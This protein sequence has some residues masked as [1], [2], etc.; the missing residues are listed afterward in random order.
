LFRYG[1]FIK[2]KIVKKLEIHDQIKEDGLDRGCSICGREMKNAY[3]ILV[4]K[5]GRRSFRR[6]RH[7]W[8]DN[9]NMLS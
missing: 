5:Q 7:R 8:E 4:G 2:D 1:K 9:F 6:S 3:K